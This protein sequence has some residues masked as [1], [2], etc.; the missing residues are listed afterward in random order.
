[1]PANIDPAGLWQVIRRSQFLCR[2]SRRRT[3]GPAIIHKFR[4][5]CIDQFTRNQNRFVNA[6]DLQY[7]GG[8]VVVPFNGEPFFG[9]LPAVAGNGNPKIGGGFLNQAVPV[10]FG[11]VSECL[12]VAAH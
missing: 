5:P 1:M 12:F 9:C 7:L 6:L 4:D 11:D 10:R 2:V 8:G 3:R